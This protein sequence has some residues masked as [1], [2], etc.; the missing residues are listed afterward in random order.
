MAVKM[1]VVVEGAA[2]TADVTVEVQAGSTQVEMVSCYPLKQNL[3]V[4][5]LRI[6]PY[7]ILPALKRA[8]LHCVHHKL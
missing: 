1:E 8:P 3:M 7:S 4:S 5:I 2:E 6:H